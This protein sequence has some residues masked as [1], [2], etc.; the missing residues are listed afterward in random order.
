MNATMPLCALVTL[1]SAIFGQAPPSSSPTVPRTKDQQIDNDYAAWKARNTRTPDASTDKSPVPVQPQA[2]TQPV[3]STRIGDHKI[4][5]AFWAWL[6]ITSGH[7][8]GTNSTETNLAAFCKSQKRMDW[9]SKDDCKRLSVIQASG[10]GEFATFANDRTLLWSFAGGRVAEVRIMPNYAAERREDRR[11]DFQQELSFLTQT[12]GKPSEIQSVPYHNAY[13]AHWE[14]STV[15]WNM[16]D[17][18]TIFEFEAREF[19]KQGDVL[20]IS[21]LSKEAAAKQVLDQQSK[22]NPYQR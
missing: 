2:P 3:E 17:G 13:G 16:P 14:R 15:Q 9:K 18:T 11:L 5:E 1:A 19:D 12:Y 21:F 8:E 22:P 10:Q 7:P 6:S 20:S 4:G